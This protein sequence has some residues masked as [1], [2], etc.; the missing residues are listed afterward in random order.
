[1][2]IYSS[3]FRLYYGDMEYRTSGASIWVTNGL[4]AFEKLIAGASKNL[5]VVFE[6]PSEIVFTEYDMKF[7]KSS[8]TATFTLS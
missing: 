1:M 6:V 4:Y 8:R 2:Y 3:D 5:V 7:K